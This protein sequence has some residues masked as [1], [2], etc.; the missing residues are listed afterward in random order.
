MTQIGTALVAGILTIG[1][2]A[3]EV[4]PAA[5]A[6]VPAWQSYVEAPSSAVVSPVR[7][8]STSG[9]VIN[10]AALVHRG[11][12]SAT[13]TYAPGGTAPVLVLDYG[14]EVGGFA[15]FDIGAVSGAPALRAAYS[16]TLANLSSTGD[17]A[18]NLLTNGPSG[19]NAR[20]D[21]WPV[22]STGALRSP[23]L[24]GGERYE[25]VTLDSPGS[26]TLKSAAID[27][28]G[29][30]GTANALR[31]HF[32]S[33][34]GLLNRIWYA[35]VYTL[36]LNQII[37]GTS[38]MPGELDQ[39]AVLIDG[40]K[41]DRAVWSG[42]QLIADPTA[43][44]SIDP[45][46]VRNS[47]ALFGAHPAT[48]ANEYAVA[49][50]DPSQPGPL[51]GECSPNTQ[52]FPQCISWSASYSMDFVPALYD[53]YLYTGDAGFV[54]QQWPMVVRQMAWD[55]E[56]VD[57]NGLVSVNDSDNAD[58][59]GNNPSGE[60]TY[61]NSVYYEALNAAAALAGAIGKPGAGAYRAAAAGIKGAVNRQLWDAKLGIYDASTS[62]RGPIVQDANVFAVLSGIAS[63]ERG[64]G[65]LDVLGRSLAS[66]YGTLDVS[67]PV[68][69]GYSQIVSPFIGGFQLAADFQSNRTHAAL[70]L[71]R[72][73]WGW[74]VGHDP[75]GTDWEKIEPGGAPS[76]LDSTAHAWGTGA[77]SAL[78]QY[79]LGVA[80]ATAG[81]RTWT[82][83]PHPGDI[84]WAEGS[85]PTPHGPIGVSWRRG[86]GGSSFRVALTAPHGT[87]GSVWVP[88]GAS[89]RVITRDGRIVW[90][91]GVG[92]HSA[93]AHREGDYVVLEHQ[94]GSHAYAWSAARR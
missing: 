45:Q 60:L 59:A 53:Y 5:A 8:V 43:Y 61:V 56:Q 2:L 17:L 15:T 16:E 41:R 9:S 73:E 50:G 91:P 28:T 88:L 33:S 81:Y 63:P 77:T 52:G 94:S 71:I 23:A 18:P 89:S 26:V 69:S 68:P 87:T 4:A 13:L 83:M 48:L 46:Y 79:V 86:T 74:M 42:D 32:L 67:S 58:W 39:S 24:Q 25:L 12:G 65:I 62:N 34:D 1:V 44:Y 36:N 72:T 11:G 49:V 35:G 75:G 19:N 29:F 57:A 7:V 51:P 3:A 27:F 64:R 82:V 47:L 55:A 84:A 22:T 10:A 93:S 76:A 70:A 20:F 80:P 38:P 14:K 31:G 30:L 40:A 90:R 37:P 66:R 6:T 85:V 78:S 54:R 21:E 92:A